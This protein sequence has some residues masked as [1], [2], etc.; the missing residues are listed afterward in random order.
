MKKEVSCRIVQT[1]LQFLE[2]HNRPLD[3]L[4]TGVPYTFDHLRNKHE[5]IEWDAFCT[6]V[7]N[8]R[9]IASDEDFVA[10]GFE[11]VT[12][13]PFRSALMA[14]QFLLNGPQ[15][16]QWWNK[17][18]KGPAHHLISCIRATTEV[19]SKNRVTV[20]LTL[21]PGHR[22]CRDFFLATKGSFTAS[23]TLIGLGPSRVVMTEREGGARYEIECPDVSAVS[24]LKKVFLWPFSYREAARE[25]KESN[26][27]LTEQY[28]RLEE[29]QT[30]SLQQA[31]RLKVAYDISRLIHTRLDLDSTLQAIANSLVTVAGFAAASLTVDTVSEGR[32]VRRSSGSGT[33]LDGSGPITRVLEG[34]GEP[35]GEAALWLAPG[36]DQEEAE[37]LLDYIIPTIAM[38]IDDAL[39]FALVNDYRNSLVQKVEERTQELREMNETLKKAQAGRDRLFTNISHEL[40]TPLTLILGPLDAVL[41]HS[42]A[43]AIRRRLTMMKK[44]GDRLLRLINQ[45]LELAK[46]Q[47]GDV[48]LNASPVKFIPQLRGIVKSFQSL[49]DMRHIRLIFQ[50]GADS[51]V[52]NLDRDK[53]EMLFNNLLVNAFKYTPDGGKIGVRVSEVES[54][55]EIEVR[56]S[57]A[58]IPENEL[59]HIFDRFYQGSAAGQHNIGGTGIGL[60]LAKELTELHHGTIRVSSA[61]GVGS[62]FTIN[63]PLENSQSRLGEGM[64]HAVPAAEASSPID[65]EIPAE[66]ARTLTR[67]LH[68]RKRVV[69]VID[70]DPD[71]RLYIKDILSRDVSVIEACDGDEGI[72]KAQKVMPDLII[73]DIMMPKRDGNEV[74]RVLK[75]DL[76]TSHIPVILL[77]AR[78]GTESRIKGLETGA[79]DYIVKP[80]IS[81]ELLARVKNLIALRESLRERFSIEWGMKSD[82]S[83]ILPREQAFLERA[84]LVIE[85]HIADEKFSIDRFSREIGLSRAQLHRKLIA[86]TDCSA[87]DFVRR[88]RIARGGDLLRHDAGTISEIAYQ[89]GFRDPSHFAK[90]FRRQ[91]GVAPGSIRPHRR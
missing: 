54:G 60:A 25:L 20:T 28:V 29:M 70:D 67:R 14:G 50:S 7:G 77:T 64:A 61:V 69:L 40:R 87:R 82:D 65:G 89:V 47:S 5:W 81:R 71:V 36:S 80:F 32:P 1:T 6:F 84:R 21:S 34:H 41:E 42:R 24:R 8:V 26:D 62:A 72:R 56:D 91:F 2:R 49:A 43:P 27:L 59:P 3:G 57:G 39:S 9:R 76:R 31:T 35:I 46:L 13:V 74:C 30:Q 22:Y 90:C 17:Y 66:V 52:L 78:A 85:E 10:M 38:E 37:E 68:G 75:E 4:L 73:S 79:D 18:P 45:L 11:S 12:S 44:S 48:T 15:L 83:H 51:L 88:I 58:G 23:T 63:L 19:H 86:L 55:A 16:F 53:V 33:T